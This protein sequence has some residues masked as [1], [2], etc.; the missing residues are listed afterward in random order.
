MK[1]FVRVITIIIVFLLLTNSSVTHLRAEQVTKNAGISVVANATGSRSSTVDAVTRLSTV[2]SAHARQGGGEILIIPTTEMQQQ[3]MTGLIEDM[4]V[5][6]RIFDKKLSQSNLI[7][8]LP[9]IGN[10]IL[11]RH[12]SID[13][14]S[15]KAM[16]IQGYGALFVLDVDFPLAPPPEKEEK[17]EAEQEGDPLWQQM[18]KEIFSPQ[19]AA[20]QTPGRQRREYD[21]DKVNDLKTTI[22]KAL[23]HAANIRGLKPDESVVLTI[24]GSGASSNIGTVSMTNYNQVIVHYKDKNVTKVLTSPSLSDLG[25]SLPVVMVIRAK[26]SYIDALAQDKIDYDQFEQKVQLISYPSL[27]KTLGRGSWLGEDYRDAYVPSASWIDEDVVEN[28]GSN[29]RRSSRTAR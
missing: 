14:R 28:A 17:Q 8:E 10:L 4:T 13:S 16:Y 7:S 18:K 22:K 19:E 26:K 20:Q 21:P 24:T 3:E 23:V 5:M 6:C 2:L 25:I 15:M 1:A 29:I 11:P 27:D 9:L 12:S